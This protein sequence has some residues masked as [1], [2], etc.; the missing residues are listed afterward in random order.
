MRLNCGSSINRSLCVCSYKCFASRANGKSASEIRG[1]SLV[2]SRV[3]D[4]TAHPGNEKDKIR[5]F[6]DLE[7]ISLKILSTKPQRKVKN[8]IKKP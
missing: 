1:R 8:S 2:P 5:K 4:G 6:P 7:Q 3:V